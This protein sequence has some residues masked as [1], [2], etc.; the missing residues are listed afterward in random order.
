MTNKGGENGRSEIRIGR[1]S[2]PVARPSKMMFPKDG[3][4]K[5]DLAEYYAAVS[6]RM[7]PHMKDRPV[8]M[9]RYP[10]GIE[11]QRFYQKEVGRSAPAWLRTASVK[12]AGGHLTQLLCNDAATLV[13]LADQACITPHVWLSRIDRPDRPDQLIFDLDPPDGGFQ[14]ARIAALQL[15]GL[16]EELGLDPL[17]KTSGGKGLHVLVWLERRADFD[18][19]RRFARAVAR[20]LVDRDP[21]HLTLEHGKEGRKGRLFVDVTRD[22]YAQHIAPPY[23]VRAR[24]GAPVSTPLDWNEVEDRSLSPS[25]FSIRTVRRRL[26]DDGDPW[27]QVRRRNS[28]AGAKKA[29][30]DLTDQPAA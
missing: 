17:A 3:I 26:A 9:E 30:A 2:V 1:R 24:P 16:L 15:R 11:G 28:L 8:A 22:A 23:S 7:V 6:G 19:V 25:R 5:S 12:K 20:H 27:E 18:E 10:D 13:Y 29:L 14:R 21:K 4:T